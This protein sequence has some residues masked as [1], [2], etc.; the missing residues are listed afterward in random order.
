MQEVLELIQQKQQ[1]FAQLPLFQFLEDPKVD[2]RQK[3]TFTPFFAFFV[4]SYADLNKYVLR[5]EPTQDAVQELINNHT[6]EEE[7]HWFWFIEDLKQ[8]GF[9]KTM[10]LSETLKFLWSDESKVQR[11]VIYKLFHLAAQGSP[12]ER[13]VLMEAIEATA[14]IFLEATKSAALGLQTITHKRYRYFG[15]IHVIA[16]SSH[17]IYSED[18][19]AFI[20]GIEI[21]EQTRET[22]FALVEEVFE[23]FTTLMNDLLTYAQSQ[24]VPQ[25]WVLEPRKYPEL[26]SPLSADLA[27][28]HREVS[29]NL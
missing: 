19:E 26:Q 4:M 24:P 22:L 18:V 7:T 8:L 5:D 21:T 15:D 27:R 3:L 11:Q 6:Y 12:V 10:P 9:D 2:P 25:H 29:I 14:D 1:A 13:L 20:H 17:A 23:I 28:L 16:D